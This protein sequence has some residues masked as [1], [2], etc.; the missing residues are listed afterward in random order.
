MGERAGITTSRVFNSGVD[1]LRIQGSPL[2]D[3][4]DRELLGSFPNPNEPYG[5]RFGP[6]CSRYIC[7]VLVSTMLHSH[8]PRKTYVEP[9][10][11]SFNC[12]VLCPRSQ[13]DT[14]LFKLIQVSRRQNAISL[15]SRGLWQRQGKCIQCSFAGL[16]LLTLA[17]N[18]EVQLGTLHPS[19]YVR[20][21]N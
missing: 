9:Q 10:I 6:M 11:S 21:C 16:P 20:H 5:D 2:S 12:P 1:D 8:G 17:Q 15:S 3:M 7:H 13:L 4:D 14:S 19:W 18:F